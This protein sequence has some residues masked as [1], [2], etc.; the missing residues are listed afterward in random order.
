MKKGEKI[1]TR[2]ELILA[3]HLYCRL[4]FGKLHRGTPEIIQ[5]AELIVR[6]VNAVSY[7]L[8]NLASLDPSLQARGISG[9]SNHSKLDKIIWDEFFE[10]TEDLIAEYD[11]ILAE[12]SRIG[13]RH[14]RDFFEGFKEGTETE[15]MIKTR[16]NQ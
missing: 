16:N 3:I 5:L 14:D 6:S 12:F 10:N 7:K 2:E 13:T 1:W 9:A 15:R 11:R 8:N 4:P